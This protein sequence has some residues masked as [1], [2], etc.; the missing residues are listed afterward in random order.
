MAFH[1][2][3]GTRADRSDWQLLRE[4]LENVARLAA[5]MAAPFGLEKIAYLAGLFHDLGKFDPDFQKRLAGAQIGVDH[6]T[7]GAVKLLELAT[8]RDRG[9]AELAAYAILG[10]HAGLPDR[11]NETR[12]CVDRR[13]A[14]FADRLDPQWRQDLEIDATG[15]VPGFAASFGPDRDKAA[16]QFSVMARMV[17]SCLVDADFK[18]TEA[19]YTQLEDRQADRHW[20]SL[21]D[22]LPVFLERFDAHMAGMGPGDSSLNRLRA[23]VLS[24]VR[25]RAGD[26]PG[27][28]TL[29]VPTG[30]GKTLASL[31][32]AL[33]HAR[34]HG[35][36]RIIYAIPFTSVID[37]TAAIFRD[38]LGGQHV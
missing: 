24:H 23:D 18:D 7:A 12:A 22:L 13:F 28:F 19:F 32:F 5:E 29:T 36:R 3:S 38:V 2:H 1:A 21:Q 11:L 25:G 4:H 35:H 26:R 33:D 30:G 15:L 14:E 6:S 27:L 31:G 34:R 9:M 10:H 8:G 37:Q 20:Q 17:F 16:F